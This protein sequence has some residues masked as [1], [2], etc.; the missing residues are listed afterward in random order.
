VI[1][2]L[3]LYILKWRNQ[4]FRYLN[5]SSPFTFMNIIHVS[6]KLKW[7]VMKWFREKPLSQNHILFRVMRTIEV[8]GQTK[9]SM[10]I[11]ITKRIPITLSSPRRQVSKENLKHPWV[12]GK[13]EE[14]LLPRK[15]TN[16]EVTN[17]TISKHW[18][19][20]NHISA[21]WNLKSISSDKIWK[22]LAVFF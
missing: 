13:S 6:M 2:F 5:I 7:D 9:L 14:E 11:F 18:S 22:Y 12:K 8:W 10:L 15:P 19:L 16:R 20:K 17:Y 3:I 4:R 21:P 1:W